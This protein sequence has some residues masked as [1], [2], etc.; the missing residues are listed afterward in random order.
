MTILF[1]TIP[2][3]IR[4]PSNNIEFNTRMAVH[5]L[6]ANVKKLMLL[7]QKIKDPSA[8]ATTHAYLEG[9]IVNPATANGHL[10]FCVT[11]GTSGG[12]APTWP[13]ALGGEVTDGAVVWKEFS[14]DNVLTAKRIVKQLFSDNDAAAFFGYGS[15][16]H[17]MALAALRS[18]PY[19]NIF[20][21]AEDDGAGVNASGTY[22]VT[23]TPTASGYVR[24]FVGKEFVE[25]SFTTADTPTTIAL[26]IKNAIAAKPALPVVA[27]SVEGVTTAIF[28]HAGTVGNQYALNVEYT[29][30]AGIAIT[31]AGLAS[32]TIDPDIHAAGSLLDKIAPTR[33]HRIA[34]PYNDSTSL[35]YTKDHAI[36]VSGPIE[37][38]SSVI[39]AAMVNTIASAQT[40]ADGLNDGRTLLGLVK[41]N[42]APACEIAAGVGAVECAFSDPALPRNDAEIKAAATV[43]PSENFTNTE[44]ETCLHHGITPIYMDDSG[45]MLIS[46]AI[47]TFQTNESLL[48]ITTI[49]SMDYTRDV[50]T[51]AHAMFKKMKG[52]DRTLDALLSITKGRLYMLQDEGVLRKIDD[53]IEELKLEEGT[54]AGEYRMEIPAPVVPGLHVL[55]EKIILHLN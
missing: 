49:D 41:A 29:Q 51:A 2:S 11:A 46:R 36:F 44:I 34:T 16:L 53:Y 22:T 52:T 38:R 31:A 1:D 54:E 48:D 28:K 37:K 20:A 24:A 12:T 40:I 21:I 39:I 5:S 50:M 27:K 6:P 55:N 4:R 3:G 47:T 42:K 15:M 35:G 43:A 7:G 19:L 23:G 30:G 26:A 18:N 17:R 45:A 25:I 14:T 8:H 32:G 13:T 33:Y 9:A 10:Y